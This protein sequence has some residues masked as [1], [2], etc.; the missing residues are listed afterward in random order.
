[1]CDIPCVVIAAFMVDTL[2]V[3]ESWIVAE[4]VKRVRNYYEE[5]E[6]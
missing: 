3:D 6:R 4:I 1:M 5:L 2:I